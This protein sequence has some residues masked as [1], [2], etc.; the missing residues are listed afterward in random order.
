MDD[1]LYGHLKL[2]QPD[3][4]PRVN[5]D[6]VLLASWVRIRAGKINFAELGSAAGAV[7]LMLALRFRP[8]FCITGVELQSDLTELANK[9]KVLNNLAE[10]TN[11]I[12]GDLRDKKLLPCDYF[13]GVVANPPYES[14]ERGRKSPDVSRSIARQDIY[15]N[16]Y[17]IAEAAAR[18]LKTR[19]RFFAVF[20]T[21]RMANF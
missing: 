21:D 20:K 1:I 16:T 12:T 17:D 7:S 4:G 6:T 5:M 3:S 2:L 18:L 19:G 11:F 15:A 8:P 13:D 10:Q 9:N 14:T